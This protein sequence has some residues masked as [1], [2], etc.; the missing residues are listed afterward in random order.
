MAKRKRGRAKAR[1]RGS[2]RENP[3]LLLPP[4]D[5]VVLLAFA[6]SGFA[7]LMHQVVWAK[8]LNTLIGTTAEAQAA[9]LCVFMGGLALGSFLFGRRAD[10]LG[11]PLRT[12]V[13]LEFAI[14]L[15]CALLP[16]VIQVAGY[17][18]D[19]LASHALDAPRVTFLI[20][21]GLAIL[22]VLIPAVLMGGT[23]PI[24]ARHVIGSAAETRSRVG[25]LYALNSFGAVL[26]AGVAGFISLPLPGCGRV[27]G[28]GVHAERARRV[29]RLEAGPV[30]RPSARA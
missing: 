25:A 12:Y 30:G 20:R 7:G 19:A 15:Y 17:G 21:F 5:R 18:Y 22:C 8:L 14:A 27:R 16:L 10:R 2:A 29:G 13:V 26:G 6:I 28:S 4:I 1:T 23:L 11:H 9:V 24:L 3:K